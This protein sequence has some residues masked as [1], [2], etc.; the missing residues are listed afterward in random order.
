MPLSMELFLLMLDPLSSCNLVMLGLCFMLEDV[1]ADANGPSSRKESD[2]LLLP[3]GFNCNTVW[4]IGSTCSG[5]SGVEVRVEL[6]SGLLSVAVGLA[7][8]DSRSGLLLLTLGL[9]REDSRSGLLLLTLG[10]MR[11][12]SRSGLLSATFGLEREA[13]LG[14]G[15]GFVREPGLGAGTG[16]AFLAG[17]KPFDRG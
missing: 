1:F 5:A 13:G 8:E 12:D 7:R 11:E 3:L 4:L 9:A 6:R 2:P 10:L 15:T 14:A 17:F 16:G